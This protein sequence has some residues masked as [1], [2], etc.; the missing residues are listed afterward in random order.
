MKKSSFTLIELLVVIAI[1]AI[2]AAI[3]LPALQQAR[4]RAMTTNCISNL[5][6]MSTVGTMYMQ[7]NR[8]LWHNQCDLSTNKVSYIMH[9]VRAKLVPDAADNNGQTFASCPSTPIRETGNYWRQVYG[10]QYAN[11]SNE[12]YAFGA[13][14]YVRDEPPQNEAYLK[15][16]TPIAGATAALSKRVML[17]DSAHIFGTNP[18]SQASHIAAI[19]TNTNT[20]YGAPYFVH[21]GRSNVATFGGNVESLAIDQYMNEYFFPFNGTTGYSVLPSRYF[22]NNGNLIHPTR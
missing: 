2:L 1:I 8:D 7:A 5:K 13:G 19:S 18:I 20:I 4:E 14:L 17:S 16:G 6:Q 11:N 9:L 21:G 3:L 12:G 10:T 22:D 15:E